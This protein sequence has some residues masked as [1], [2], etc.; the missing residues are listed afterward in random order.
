MKIICFICTAKKN[1]VVAK[2]EITVAISRLSTT[3]LKTGIYFSVTCAVHW[4]VFKSC[5]S[6][7][8]LG[9]ECL[10]ACLLLYRLVVSRIRVLKILCVCEFIGLYISSK[11][12]TK[13][14]FLYKC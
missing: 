5:L 3:T 14:T 1:I 12:F 10:V 8:G 9:W 6:N 13:K 2:A 4:P 11:L 7:V